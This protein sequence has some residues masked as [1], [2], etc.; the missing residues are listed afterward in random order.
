MPRDNRTPVDHMPAIVVL[1]APGLIPAV[2]TNALAQAFRGRVIV[3][4]ERPEGPFAVA[5]RR[6]RRLGPVTALGQLGTAIAS[7]LMKKT[8]RTRMDAILAAHGHSPDLNLNVPRLSVTSVNDAETRSAIARLKPGVIVTIACRLIG[9]ETLAASPCPII[10]FHAGINPA[11][12]GQMGGYWALALADPDNFGATIHLV[13]AGID[14]GATLYEVRPKPDRA[15][16]M[17]TYPLL[18]AVAGVERLIQAVD[19]ALS[20]NLKPVQTTGPSALHYPPTIWRWLW[21]GIRRG[22]W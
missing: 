9:R 18:L 17:A 21:T 13:D 10:N 6:A 14:T 15:D 5:R 8:S 20:G 16:S 12:R 3:I 11:Y 7:R 4:K 1:A 2:L 22:I 19:D